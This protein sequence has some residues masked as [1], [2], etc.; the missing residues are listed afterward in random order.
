MNTCAKLRSH[1][2]PIVAATILLVPAP[3]GSKALA[4]G[5]PATKG[6]DVSTVGTGPYLGPL[7][8]ELAK[9][10]QQVTS[11]ET[12]PML[13]KEPA[14]A[15][16]TTVGG[17]TL[18]VGELAKVAALQAILGALPVPLMQKLEP[19]KV[20][21][22]G[23]P[24]LTAQ[25]RDKHAKELGTPTTAPTTLPIPPFAPPSAPRSDR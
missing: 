21:M 6:P 8:E 15:T 19:M 13:A 23:I 16:T 24:T 5:P 11:A 10:P 9:L 14:T 25:E 22:D 18:T 2:I 7:P 12:G 4:D 17:N 3:R 20:A 1:L